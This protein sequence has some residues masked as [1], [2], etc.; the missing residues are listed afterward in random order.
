MR[1][2]ALHGSQQTGGLFEQRLAPLVKRL[3]DN[4]HITFIDAPH[5][6]PL[7]DGQ[8]ASLGWWREDGTGLERSLDVIEAAWRAATYDALIGFSSG[9]A[10]AFAAATRLPGLKA[11]IIAGA[12]RRTEAAAPP[13]ATLLVAGRNDKLV[14]CD[15]TMALASDAQRHLHDLGHCF[16][17]RSRDVEVYVSFLETAV[18]AARPPPPGAV[19]SVAATQPPAAPPVDAEMFAAREEELEALEAIFA[20]DFQRDRSRVRLDR[21]PFPG[22]V[23]LAF[24]MRGT[25]PSGGTLRLKVVSDLSLADMPQRASVAIARAAAA[26]VKDD[27]EAS[28]P[29][30][31]SAVQAAN[32]YIADYDLGAAEEPA[33]DDT[34][35]TE[36]ENEEEGVAADISSAEIA[37]YRA[38]AKEALKRREASATTAPPSKH[39]GE[40]EIVVGLVGKPS[41][42]KS[43]FFNAI[44][45]ATGAIA[46]KCAAFP[47][48]TID[49]NVR[50]GLYAVLDADPARA[51]GMALS[52][53]PPHGRDVQGRRLLPVLLKDVAGLVPGAYAGKGKG[54]RFLNDLCDA[55]ALVHVVDASAETD[56]G[57][58]A[59][60]AADQSE[61]VL[62][63]EISWVRDELHRWIAGNV[64]A[65]WRSVVRLARLD[66]DGTLALDRLL[67]LFNGYRASNAMARRAF[68]LAG[69]DKEQLPVSGWGKS[70]LHRLVAAFLEVRFPTVVALNKCDRPS[71]KQRVAELLVD[72]ATDLVPCCARVEAA[73]V[74][75]RAA[76][77]VTYEDG[78]GAFGGDGPD[79]ASVYLKEWGTTGVL[80]AISRAVARARPVHAYPVVDLDSLRGALSPGPLATCMAFRRWST[81]EDIFIALK[82]R[83][84]GGDFVRA[85]AL[86]AD[87]SRRRQAKL[88]DP[89]GPDMAV[90]KVS[91]NRKAAWQNG[92]AA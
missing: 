36:S 54:N 76:G 63:F 15:E 65:K 68:E 8:E 77:A 25:Y 40:F 75:A 35:A 92:A 41:A 19:E 66:R 69:L 34:A 32:D 51:L 10:V 13:C 16:P 59:V 83:G 47:F 14:P 52:E 26:A 91:S 56:A 55:N 89:L 43:T 88:K 71:V 46:A 87:G 44:T 82:R 84:G 22:D 31:M 2:L 61:D 50:E 27:L 4:H 85:D 6:L 11:L 70:Q 49:P 20:D 64:V 29:C 30:L 57:G 17:C 90:L 9:G 7:R 79:G 42:G 53:C 60:D 38:A 12:P 39:R 1:V 74:V 80:D 58:A 3:G 62:A 67:D 28:E 86:S 48:T 21:G 33:E 73:L 24:E 78:A 72:G 18:A 23:Y 5:A 45:R 37:A 81:V